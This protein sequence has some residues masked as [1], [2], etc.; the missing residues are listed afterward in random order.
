MFA[1]EEKK[2]ALSSENRR[3]Y[4]SSYFEDMEK[5]GVSKQEKKEAQ[6]VVI[7]DPVEEPQPKKFDWTSWG[8]LSLI[9]AFATLA[10]VILGKLFIIVGAAV[11]GY[12]FYWIGGLTL[13]ASLGL[14]AAQMIKSNA[15][16]FEP[17]LLILML[18]VFAFCC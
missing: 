1:D 10:L 12:I 3:D 14:Y 6:K 7:E 15:I 9:A 11:C 16:K 4:Y 8:N 18:S 5:E 2:V 13:L 17:Q